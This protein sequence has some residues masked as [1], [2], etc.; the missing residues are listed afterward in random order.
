MFCQKQNN[1]IRL[2]E[3]QNTLQAHYINAIK[4][5]MAVIEFDIDG[6]I[7]DA[8]NLFLEATG[9]SLAEVQGQ[10][11]KIFVDKNESG[12]PE[13]QQF[14]QKLALGE[15]QGGLYRRFNKQGKEVWLQGT[16]NPIL[17]EKGQVI[18]VVKFASDV[19]EQT[20]ENADLENQLKAI[21][22]SMASIE[23]EADGTIIKANE[24]FLAVLGYG[25][26]EIIGKHHQMFVSEKEVASAEYKQFWQD[27]KNG[28][29]QQGTYKRIDKQGETVWLE[30]SYNPVFDSAGQ[31]Y[32]VVKYAM[33]V[34][35]NDLSLAISAA[36]NESNTV[37][38]AFSQGDLTQR[39]QGDYEGNLGEL[40]NAINQTA[41]ELSDL[42]AKVQEVANVVYGEAEEVR[43]GSIDLN[44]RVQRQAAAL[45]ETSATMHEMS[46]AVQNNNR[47]A[48]EATTLSEGVQK[49]ALEGDKVMQNT[50]QAMSGIEESS[51]RINDIVA[52]IDS[53]A[54]Q[55]NLLALNAA[56]EAARAGE[57]GR[58]FAVVAGEVRSL[59][60]K[61]A[62]AAKDI[63]GLVS[64]SSARVTQGSELAT[65]SGASL[66]EMTEEVAQ[67]HKMMQQITQ[68]SQEQEQ[69]VGQVHQA[70]AEID[71]TTQQN[72]ALVEET[73]AT[74]EAMKQQAE[75]LLNMVKGFKMSDNRNASSVAKLENLT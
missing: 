42:I 20:L 19:T 55:T 69:G 29:F 40:K 9:Y 66:R 23:F 74:S 27:L 4:R 26:D 35:E 8:N 72:A 3:K 31:V 68:A 22:R 16:Y 48:E 58:G 14:W 38:N 73:A 1:R 39:V 21:D 37:L 2:L 5:S 75:N 13:Y 52:L 59:A 64:D 49:K 6:H 71:G 33:D 36:V 62:D 67:V 15:F 18:K 17:D 10:H 44:D 61:A 65:Q 47:N 12:T 63:T 32:K 7:L 56:V 45:E 28:E 24:N 53:I 70:I 46:S 25:L 60:Q 51:Q 34:T 11:H 57:H 54:F 43:Q 41:V 30:A 50:I